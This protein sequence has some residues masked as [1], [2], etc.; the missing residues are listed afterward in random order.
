M[1]AYKILNIVTI[2]FLAIAVWIYLDFFFCFRYFDNIKSD[3]LILVFLSSGFI[4]LVLS[5]ISVR[6][7]INFIGISCLVVI[8]LLVTELFLLATRK[9]EYPV[10]YAT[11]CHIKREI[12]KNTLT[13]F[14]IDE[15]NYYLQFVKLDDKNEAIANDDFY[16]FYG[17]ILANNDKCEYYPRDYNFWTQ[18]LHIIA[19]DSIYRIEKAPYYV[20]YIH[21]DY[22]FDNWKRRWCPGC[23]GDPAYTPPD[24]VWHFVGYSN[25]ENLLEAKVLKYYLE[26]KDK[27][28]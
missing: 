4:V 6:K 22:N 20:E 2:I 25:D 11:Y 8:F 9:L 27:T 17:M 10:S 5:I 3:I 24:T 18:Y 26:N 19:E 16:L 7:K 21:S 15:K 1:K 23:H 13:V 14:K 28:E 12:P